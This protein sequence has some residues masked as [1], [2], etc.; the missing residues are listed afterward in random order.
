MHGEKGS[1]VSDTAIGGSG[2]KELGEGMMG[3]ISNFLDQ[4]DTR[5]VEKLT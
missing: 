5:F 4:L 1:G 2:D 3:I